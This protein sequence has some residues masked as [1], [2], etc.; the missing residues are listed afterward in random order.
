MKKMR[1]ILIA[2]IVCLF[3][4]SIATAAV[5]SVYGDLNGDKNVNAIDFALLKKYLLDNS[6]VFPVENGA[7]Y[8]DLNGDGVVSVLDYALL[9]SYLLGKISTFPVESMINANIP[10]DWAGVI[11]T[12]QSLSVGVQGTPIETT[13]QPFNNITLSIKNLTVPPFD[14]N[15]ASLKMVPLIEPV[16]NYATGYPSPYPGNICGETHHSAMANQITSLVR[17]AFGKDYIT[18]HTVVGE[19]GQGIVALRKGATDNGSTG[20]AYAATMFEVNA[21]KR[22]AAE[23]GK[24]YGVGAIT[25][26]HG[27]TDSGNTLYEDELHKLWSDYNQDIKAITG[28]T[29]SIPLLVVQQHSCGGNGTSASLLA[30]WRVGVDYPGDIICIGPNYQNF[31]ADDGVHLTAKGYQQL[32]EQFAKVYYQKVVLGKDW[33]PLQPTGAERTGNVIKVNFNVPEGPLVWDTKLPEPNQ[34][35][36]GEWKNG[37]GF[38][39]STSNKRITI[40]SVQISGNS[41]IITCDGEL[42]STGVKV[43]YAFN[44]EGTRRPSGTY[45][46]G[47]LRD[48]DQFKGYTSGN[49]IPNYCVSF[50]MD[51][52]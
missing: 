4:C 49:V 32:G 22:L 38:E 18:A 36:Y 23:A 43:G 45:R 47:L 8:A 37:K 35:N 30:Q 14:V 3:S 33:Q 50:E 5:S 31:Y 27:E 39:V 12:G 25:I 24:T 21:I 17:S 46:W 28:Q 6:Y 19:S 26:V 34:N 9:K 1:L 44:A 42:P 2:V 51:V 13:T 15:D 52:N 48:S 16:H 29:Q 10:W 20:R 7:K 11:G 40:S 41:V